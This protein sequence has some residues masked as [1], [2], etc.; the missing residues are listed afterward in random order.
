MFTEYDDYDATGLARLVRERQV[1]PE[2]LL[3]AAIAR[4]EQ[5]DPKINAVVNKMYD[6][7]F[8]TGRC[9]VCRSC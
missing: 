5:R 2:Q 4:V 3:E 1:S 7:A 6:Q 9:A 8:P